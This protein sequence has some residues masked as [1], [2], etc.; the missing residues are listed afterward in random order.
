MSGD[1]IAQDISLKALL[2]RVGTSPLNLW[3]L[4]IEAGKICPDIFATKVKDGQ[5]KCLNFMELVIF[6]IA[7]ETRQVKAGKDQHKSVL[8]T[9]QLL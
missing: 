9:A 1:Y 5:Y 3:A 8:R 7:P 4:L 6:K 2:E